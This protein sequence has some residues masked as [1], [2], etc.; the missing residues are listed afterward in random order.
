MKRWFIKKKPG[1][2]SCVNT[3]NTFKKLL[4]DSWAINLT[5]TYNQTVQA[6]PAGFKPLTLH[7]DVRDTCHS[8]KIAPH[9][10]GQKL[11]MHKCCLASAVSKMHT[12]IIIHFDRSA[13]RFFHS[14]G[15]N[16][17]SRTTLNKLLKRLWQKDLIPSYLPVIIILLMQKLGWCK[18]LPRPFIDGA[19]SVQ[20]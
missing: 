13:K 17:T 1:L 15:I 4:L 3:V 14:G 19:A 18:L 9:F 10:Q 11:V 6:L 16:L 12:A 2:E 7:L 20:Q 5:R 8:A